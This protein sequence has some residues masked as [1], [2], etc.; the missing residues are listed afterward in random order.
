M[1]RQSIGVEDWAWRPHVNTFS[2][3]ERLEKCLELTR[4]CSTNN[5]HLITGVNAIKRLRLYVFALWGQD[6]VSVVRIRE[7]PYYRGFFNENI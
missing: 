5:H 2:L 4:N 3:V 1:E 6:L 7:G